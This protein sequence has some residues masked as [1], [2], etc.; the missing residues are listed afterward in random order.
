MTEERD[1]W[2]NEQMNEGGREEGLVLTIKPGNGDTFKEHEEQQAHATGG[3]VIKEF[4]DINAPLWKQKRWERV[5]FPWGPVHSVHGQ[6]R[7]CGLG[8]GYTASRRLEGRLEEA[9]RSLWP[10][11]DVG[12]DSGEW[13]E[14][15][16][17]VE[18]N[19]PFLGGLEGRKRSWSSEP[20]VHNVKPVMSLSRSSSI[21]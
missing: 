14:N 18:G 16:Q 1:E 13:E 11:K 4:E 19:V 15:A 2:V 10:C 8:L 7:L 3:V 5:H 17:V 9:Q 12:M 6:H 21:A 20:S